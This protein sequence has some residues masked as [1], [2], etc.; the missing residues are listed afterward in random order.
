MRLGLGHLPEGEWPPETFPGYQAPIVMAGG[1][2][3]DGVPVLQL[4]RFGLIPRWSKNLKAG[5]DMARKTYNA[6]SESVADKPSY[7]GPW[8]ARQ[9]ALVPMENFYEPC[10][11]TGKAVR[12]CI[13]QASRDP[14]AAAALWERWI[15]QA[16]GQ[17]ISSF[18]LLTVNADGHALMGR[19]HRPGDEKRSLVIVPRELWQTWLNATESQ[20]IA[21]LQAPAA[22]QLAGEPAALPARQPVRQ[23]GP[24]MPMPPAAPASV[25]P[26]PQQAALFE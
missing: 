20:A 5:A 16:S 17:A 9:F 19:M 6:R 11:E 1:T 21:L 12:W 8:R 18:S 4:A 22:G 23:R 26:S 14:I 15:D 10:W 13:R 25:P 2:P 24:A 3:G 7:R